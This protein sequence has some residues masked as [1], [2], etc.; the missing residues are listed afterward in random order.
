VNCKALKS[1]NRKKQRKCR[2]GDG[3]GKEEKKGIGYG[4]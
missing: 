2:E 4:K 3:N 1:K